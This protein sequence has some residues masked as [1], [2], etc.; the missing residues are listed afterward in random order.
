MI[1]QGPSKSVGLRSRT[2]CKPQPSGIRCRTYGENVTRKLC[3]LFHLASELI[4]ST[5]VSH[6][7][8]AR[9]ESQ[10]RLLDT[11]HQCVTP[12]PRS[13]W[14]TTLKIKSLHALINCSVVF[15]FPIIPLYLQSVTRTTSFAEPTTTEISCVIVGVSKQVRIHVTSV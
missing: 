12:S 2:R 8:P 13:A 15:S 6:A 5:A 9:A 1:K 14:I 4:V 7:T 11:Y 3:G 10:S